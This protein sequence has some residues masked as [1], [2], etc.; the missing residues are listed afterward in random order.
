MWAALLQKRDAAQREAGEARAESKR[1][2]ADN[3]T[4]PE[5]LSAALQRIEKADADLQAANDNIAAYQR[6]EKLEAAMPALPP[7]SVGTTVRL[8]AEDDPRRGFSS[9]GSFGAVVRSSILMG[10]PADERLLMIAHIDRD[11]RGPLATSAPSPLHQETHSTDGYMVPPEFRREIWTPAFAA[12][13]LLDLISPSP[14]ESN[15]VVMY[16]DE[17]TPWGGAGIVAY[18]VAEGAPITATK[19]GTKARQVPLHKV[20]ALVHCTDETLADIPLLNQRLS[21]LAPQAIAWEVVEAYVRGSGTGKPLG[22]E[23]APALVTVGKETSQPAKTINT[24]NLGK[25]YGRMYRGPG[26]KPLFL[27]KP[28]TMPELLELKSGNEPSWMP[29]DK[30]MTMAP[31]A[32]ILG[33]RLLFTEHCKK[34]GTAGDMQAVNLAGYAAFIRSGGT[35]FDS[36]IHLYFDRDVTSFR[37]ITRVGG[38]PMLSQP[39]TPADDDDPVSHF[40]VLQT[41]S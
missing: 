38:Q 20:A 32:Y 35:R 40:V 16:V 37:W 10:G 17:T 1:L 31:Q 14:T 39:I 8:R 3:A 7:A 30:G 41:R 15:A 9:L 12:D 33:D 29:Q 27:A 6:A 5:Q 2:R 13:P 36:S 22:W 28:S 25:M 19:S 4:T 34:L 26:A 23:S 21:E 24:K 11:D 18:W